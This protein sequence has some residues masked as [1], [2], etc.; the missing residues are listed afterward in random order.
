MSSKA[1]QMSKGERIFDIFLYIALIL[2]MIV[3]LYPFLNVLAISFNES[4][5]TVRG[6]IYIF[7]GSGLWRITSGS[8]AIR[9]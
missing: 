3:T 2:I 6:G 7:R 9:A 8:S 4:T 5:D 1:F